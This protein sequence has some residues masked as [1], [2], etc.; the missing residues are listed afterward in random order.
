MKKVI[1][2]EIGSLS[3]AETEQECFQ[4]ILWIQSFVLIYPPPVRPLY[5]LSGFC[6]LFPFS[7]VSGCLHLGPGDTAQLCNIGSAWREKTSVRKLKEAFLGTSSL[8][9]G[10]VLRLRL[11]AFAQS[12]FQVYLCKPPH[13]SGPD[14]DCRLTSQLDHQ[15]VW[16]PWIYL[17]MTVAE[18]G[19]Y[20]QTCSAA[21][22]WLLWD[23]TLGEDTALLSLLARLP[24]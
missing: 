5:A 18:P 8:S 22:V 19:H 16:S 2:V 3:E 23:S 21:L 20:H 10:V 7:C 13:W 14:T 12:V 11:L 17:K 24:S 1:I 9:L 15:P 4:T 6:N